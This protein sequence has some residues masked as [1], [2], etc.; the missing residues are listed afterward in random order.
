[1]GACLKIVITVV[2]EEGP[3]PIV[4]KRKLLPLRIDL[5]FGSPVVNHPVANP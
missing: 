2:E 3:V 1:M 4:P 5:C